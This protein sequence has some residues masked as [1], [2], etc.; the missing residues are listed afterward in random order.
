PPISPL[1]PYTTLFRSLPPGGLERDSTPVVRVLFHDAD[2][3][4]LPV[5]PGLRHRLRS[6]GGDEQTRLGG[7]APAP[8]CAPVHSNPGFLPRGDR[9]S[10]R[11]NS[12]HVSI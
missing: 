3:D 11:L 2:G 5:R 7:A 4:R 10:T 6:H 9:K 1:F 12:S 8:R